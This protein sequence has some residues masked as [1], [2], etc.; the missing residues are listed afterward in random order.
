MQK[1]VIKIETELSNVE[2]TCLRPGS[3]PRS[4]VSDLHEII[5]KM[6]AEK[7]LIVSI[8]RKSD[9]TITEVSEVLRQKWLLEGSTPDIRDTTEE[10]YCPGF[11]SNFTK[12]E[13]REQMKALHPKRKFI[14][15][16]RKLK[17]GVPEVI[18]NGSAGQGDQVFKLT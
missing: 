5:E 17:G 4:S 7:K 15:A 13:K 12:D 18:E 2:Y 3:C 1:V 11:E 6:L 14:L 16:T 10:F 8:V 9:T